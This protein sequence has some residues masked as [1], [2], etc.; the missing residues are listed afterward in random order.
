MVLWSNPTCGIGSAILGLD[1]DGDMGVIIAPIAGLLTHLFCNHG[2][3]PSTDTSSASVMARTRLSG[4]WEG[5]DCGW[6]GSG[7]LS[8][9]WHDR[10]L[11]VSIVGFSRL[12]CCRYFAALEWW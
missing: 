9:S 8:G 6:V 1:S 2:A 7:S 10:P 12:L 5:R 4:P 3:M 11:L